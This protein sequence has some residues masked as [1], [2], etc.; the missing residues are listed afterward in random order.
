L[1]TR[2]RLLPGVSASGSA[3]ILVG[4]LCAVYSNVAVLDGVH[5]P[6]Y[7]PIPGLL[8][9]LALPSGFLVPWL[10]RV[11]RF[12]TAL[13]IAVCLDLT[14]LM[15]GG[16]VIDLV[17]P[18]FGDD[19][20]LSPVPILCV[21]DAVLALSGLV[22]VI[23]MRSRPNEAGS[24][25]A[26]DD[27]RLHGRSGPQRVTA[28][29]I[30]LLGLVAIVLAAAG[31][32]QL[33]NGSPPWVS[34]I[35][36]SIGAVLLLYLVVG[37][38]RLA[39]E[40][41]CVGLFLVSSGVLLASSL[42]GWFI[43]GPDSQREYGLYQIV[44]AADRWKP[45]SSHNAYN[46]CLSLTI[47]PKIITQ[48]TGIS[49]VYVWKSVFPVLFAL[50]TPVIF[51]FARR[52]LR[53]RTSVMAAAA[54]LS[55]PT[56]VY[57]MAFAARQEMGFLMLGVALLVMVEGA[58]GRERALA[59][60]LVASVS[61]SHYSTAYF[62]A[63]MLALTYAANLVLLPEGRARFRQLLKSDRESW[64][65]LMIPSAG[66]LVTTPLVLASVLSVGVWDGAVNGVTTS[67]AD[68]AGATIGQSVSTSGPLLNP[69]PVAGTVVS[70]TG[71]IV[72]YAHDEDETVPPDPEAK[73]YLP[74]ST[75]QAYQVVPVS[76]TDAPLTSFGKSL[77]STGVDPWSLNSAIRTVISKGYQLAAIVGLGLWVWDWR[78]RRIGP[79]PL[80]PEFFVLSLVN[81]VIVGLIFAVP[82]L[83]SSYGAP[84][85]FQQ[86]LFVLAP[87]VAYGLFRAL[88]L[89][90]VPCSQAVA[91]TVG[92]VASLSL[93]GVIPQVTGGY[94]A[95]I[96][97]NNTGVYLANYYTT[98]QEI[99]AAGW[100][101]ST[102]LHP[103]QL[104]RFLALRME[105][106][107]TEPVIND[108]YPDVLRSRSYVFF[109]TS[110]VR[111][112]VDTASGTLAYA[113][114]L[115]AVQDERSKLYSS[116]GASIYG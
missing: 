62:L 105:T 81:L 88:E 27:G 60:V 93:F 18:L 67:L 96:D 112:G 22:F 56:F 54:Y 39:E 71:A 92:F 83:T 4:I 26:E 89:A 5:T 99:A 73:G 1:A 52:F 86:A 102:Q 104:N 84:R 66:T 7:G 109:G 53:P 72:H 34:V 31:A 74:R 40:L 45:R 69:N 101:D 114:P 19:R 116:N 38:E 63:A 111:S 42:R 85:G 107:I 3:A 115:A 20:P 17:L 77:K 36:L 21:V 59:Y 23:T 44:A 47:L 58:P 100:I 49:G 12:A 75:L 16:A 8:A 65:R 15:A 14:A 24:P 97:L 43:S 106:L 57:T 94:V 48:M 37:A 103:I 78:R 2:S 35:S 82:V 51:L 30:C 55:F 29:V 80:L 6:I 32:T 79:N 76:F 46:S 10:K 113:Y 28:A 87:V 90:R 13:L 70:G 95:Q 98:P 91:C 68:V 25:A 64:R 108:D 110:L 9:V 61:L 33:N 41:L 50:T 11:F